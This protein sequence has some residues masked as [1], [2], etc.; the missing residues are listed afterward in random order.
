MSAPAAVQSSVQV[1]RSRGLHIAL[2]VVQVLLGLAFLMAGSLKS[3]QSM[4]ALA[5]MMPWTVAAGTALT[6]FIGIS[7]LAGGLGMILPAA[8]RIKPGL[9]ALAGAGLVTVMVLA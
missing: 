6:R 5:T 7:E 8:T 1:S 2:W 4:A 3:F 9:T